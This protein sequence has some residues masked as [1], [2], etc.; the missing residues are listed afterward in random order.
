MELPGL[1]ASCGE[2]SC[3]QLDF[4]PLTCKC[5]LLFCSDHFGQHAL[6]CPAVQVLEKRGSLGEVVLGNSK[7]TYVCSQLTCKNTS[8]LPLICGGCKQHFCINHRHVGECVKK[9][10]ATVAAEVERFNAP[11]MKFANAKM[12]VDKQVCTYKTLHLFVFNQKFLIQK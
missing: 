10:P 3:K 8:Y 4:L 1:G 5:G 9:D 2:P 6:S 7:A 12:E 11:A